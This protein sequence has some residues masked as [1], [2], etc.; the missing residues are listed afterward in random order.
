MPAARGGGCFAGRRAMFGAA[1]RF[2]IFIKNG[3]SFI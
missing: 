2:E 1:V 3:L